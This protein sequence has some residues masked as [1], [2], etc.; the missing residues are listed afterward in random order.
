V[1]ILLIAG[2]ASRV[3][4]LAAS[5]IQVMRMA[6]AFAALGHDVTLLVPHGRGELAGLAV[7]DVWAFYGVSHSFTVARAFAPR[8]RLG[9]LLFALAARRR[10]APGRE[11]P[12]WDF[13]LS[14]HALTTVLCA[15]AGI[16]HVYEAHHVRLRGRVDHWLLPA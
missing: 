9:E 12:P 7:P 1:R 11:A 16:R 15:R 5:S 3:P 4:S 6:G 10:A 2:S 13:I 8:S 14:R